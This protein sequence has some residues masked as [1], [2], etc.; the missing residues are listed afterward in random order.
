[1]HVRA[2]LF[3]AFSFMIAWRKRELMEKMEICTGRG[4]C[5]LFVH[6]GLS[7]VVLSSHFATP[8]LTN[9]INGKCTE[10]ERHKSD[11]LY[12]KLDQTINKNLK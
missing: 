10:E 4:V 8:C 1:M 11:I 3:Q 2:T 12:E 9:H 6:S 7:I 5:N